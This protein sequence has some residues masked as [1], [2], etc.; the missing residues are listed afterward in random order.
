MNFFEELMIAKQLSFSPG[1]IELLGNRVTIT[2]GTF[3]ADY[4]SR[5][6]DNP[7]SVIQLYE[8]AKVSFREGMAKSIGKKYGF[9]YNDFFKWLTQIA[10]LAGWGK[11]TWADLN[12]SNKSG[13]ILVDNSPVAGLLKGK[14]GLPVDHLIRGFIAG[15]ASG[16]LNTDV[17]AVEEEC[18]SLGATQC[19]FVFR[20][21][22]DFKITPEITRQLGIK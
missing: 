3:F 4:T 18:F 21:K 6:N 8:S 10:M 13:I 15:G 5:I 9:S 16:W 1:T 17:D 20:P 14:V 12:E 11:L 22:V 7:E 2:H 19:K